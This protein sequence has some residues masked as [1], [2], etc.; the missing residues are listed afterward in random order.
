MEPFKSVN[1]YSSGPKAV[2][3]VLSNISNYNTNKCNGATLSDMFLEKLAA[4]SEQHGFVIVVDEVLTG[5]WARA[6]MLNIDIVRQTGEVTGN[7]YNEVTLAFK[8]VIPYLN[9]IAEQR[10]KVL[11]LQ[12]TEKLKA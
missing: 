8:Q 11:N 10:E 7:N 6:E 1:T 4:L 9:K 5:V 2:Q 3:W 12:N